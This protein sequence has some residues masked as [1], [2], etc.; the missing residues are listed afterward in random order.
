MKKL[1]NQ[2]SG[3]GSVS[4]AIK[5]QIIETKSILNYSNKLHEHELTPSEAEVEEAEVTRP[6]DPATCLVTTSLVAD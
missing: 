3:W 2:K 4:R 1:L 6:S 5:D